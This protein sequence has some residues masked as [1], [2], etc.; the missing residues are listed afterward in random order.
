MGGRIWLVTGG[1]AGIG[2]AI[3]ARAGSE[4]ERVILLDRDGA[5]AAQTAEA[6]RE[7]GLDTTHHV[8]DLR[9]EDA[10]ATCIAAVAD[11]H[12]CIDVLVNNAGLAMREGSVVELTRKQWDLTVAVNL[13]AVY[14][15]CHYAVPH[16]PPGSAIVNVSTAGALRAVPGTDAYVAAK[17]GVIG[18]TK[19]MAVSLADRKI[20]ANA[21]CPN[22]IL[23]EEV[24]SRQG[25]PRMEAMMARSGAPLGRGHGEPEEVAAVVWFLASPDASFLNGL[26]VPVDGGATA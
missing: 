2:R 3:G 17:A 1:A 18:L 25:D 24:Q 8:V 12:G 23:T 9:D 15:T 5:R 7:A 10:V 11:E 21:V 26:A 14:L 13:T 22:V 20:R 6:A 19:A 16:M 4:G